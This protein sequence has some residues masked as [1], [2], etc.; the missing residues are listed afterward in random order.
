MGSWHKKCLIN[1]NKE[2]SLLVTS[3]A[4]WKDSTNKLGNVHIK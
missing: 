2:D 4:T 1:P 3:R